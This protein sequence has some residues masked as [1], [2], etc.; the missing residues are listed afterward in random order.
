MEHSF[1][2][3]FSGV[4]VHQG[5]EAQAMGAQAYTQGL[6][7][8][9]ASGQYDPDSQRGQELLGHELA[10]VV[11]QAQGQVRAT[12][13]AKG[14]PVNDDAALEQEA[15]EQ[16]QRAARGEPA[17][18]RA[19]RASVTTAGLHGA[20]LQAKWLRSGLHDQYDEKRD[21]TYPGEYYEWDVLLGG[22]RWYSH[23]ERNAMY[24][25]VV[26][27]TEENQAMV[28]HQKQVKTYR[29]GTSP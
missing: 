17:R 9:F 16:G 20:P 5:P 27:M 13:Q 1:G 15:D 24:F 14:R 26:Q 19:G 29:A 11:Q 28:R 8:H 10:H 25:V 2:A 12:T 4:R 23:H 6:S 18:A 22:V 3:D 21:K 7:I